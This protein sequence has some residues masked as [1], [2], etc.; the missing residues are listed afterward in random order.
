[1]Y[2]INKQE[3]QK[4]ITREEEYRQELKERNTHYMLMSMAK[5]GVN[6]MSL[7]R[8]AEFGNQFETDIPKEKIDKAIEQL[9]PCIKYSQWKEKFYRYAYNKDYDNMKKYSLKCS[10]HENESLDEL[11]EDSEGL[12]VQIDRTLHD[13]EN[14]FGKNEEALRLIANEYKK[15]YETRKDLLSIVLLGKRAE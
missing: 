6:I 10:K 15:C 5:M 9:K 7:Q 14:S 2:K 4:V 8:G 3:I 12:A 13:K 1:M 11:M